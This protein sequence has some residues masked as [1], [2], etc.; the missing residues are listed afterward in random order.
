M[1]VVV[2]GISA[3]DRRCEMSCGVAYAVF[4]AIFGGRLVSSVVIGNERGFGKSGVFLLSTA[5]VVV[6]CDFELFCE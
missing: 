5:G 3:F 1:A 6:D 4:A 2:A